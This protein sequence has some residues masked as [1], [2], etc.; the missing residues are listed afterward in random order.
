M[1]KEDKPMMIIAAI[2]FIVN[3]PYLFSIQ[4][5]DTLYMLIKIIDFILIL[6][7]VLITIR[8]HKEKRK[9]RKY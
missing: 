2:T 9:N 1:Q 8:G 4:V 6:A 7:I 3:I 5:S